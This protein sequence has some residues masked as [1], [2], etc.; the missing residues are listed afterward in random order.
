[1][2]GKTST[3]TSTV[4]IPKEVLAR[5][6][7]VNAR[8]ENT[9]S[10]PF[11]QYSTNPNA[12]V[13]PLNQQQQ[14]GI[15]NINQAATMGPQYFN[16]AAG[17][18]M[19]GAGAVNPQ[20]YSGAAVQ[21]YMNP[22]ISNVADTTAAQMK[23]LYGQQA[24]ELKGGAIR[25]G[26][27]G[28]DRAGIAQ[29]N[30]ANQQSLAFGQQMAN[31]Y[32]Q[33][34]GQAQQQFNQQQ[35][36]NLGAEQANQQRLLAA[37]QQLGGLGA[38]AQQ[39]AL[40]GAQAQLGA[41]TLGQQTEQAGL[42]ALYNQ[43]L[44]Q[45]AY[46]FQ[47]SQ[48]LANIAMGTG[49]LS[50]STQTTTQPAPFFSDER[51][52]DNIEPIGETYDGQKIVKFNYKGDKQK[53]I[54]LVAQDVE[55][56]HPEAVGLAGGLKTVDYDGATREAARMGRYM[57]GLASEGGAVIPMRAG[58]GFAIGGGV[59]EALAR[60]A[61]MYAA[62][63][64]GSV[65]TARQL[66]AGIG[67]HGRVPEA[68]LPVGRLMTPDQK[69][70]QQ[71]SGL[72]QG[73]NAYEKGAKIAEMFSKAREGLSK[74]GASAGT[75]TPSAAT[76]APSASAPTPSAA[77]K[78]DA[79]L[80][81]S[82]GE[83]T[84]YV[85]PEFEEEALGAFGYAKNGGRIRRDAGG[86]VP[87]TDE[88]T[89]S[90]KLDIPTDLPEF[91]L[92][93]HNTPSGSSGSSDLS[94]LI[95]LGKMVI[96]FLP[97]EQGGR[98]HK[99][100]GGGT[101]APAEDIP[102]SV[103]K[104][105]ISIESSGKHFDKNGQPLTSPK[106]AI[107]IAQVMPTTAP[108]AA[109]MA[110]LPFDEKRYLTDPEYN[111][112]IGKAY[113]KNQYKTFGDF[114]KAAAAYNAGPGR[115]NAAMKKAAETGADWRAFLPKETRDYIAKFASDEA[116]LPPKT[117]TPPKSEGLM[118][119][120]GMNEDTLVPLLAGV[121][122]MLS[123]RSP[124]LGSAIGEGLVGGVGAYTGL[125]GLQAEVAQR[126]AQTEE[127]YANIARSSA[128]FSPT[129]ETFFLTVGPNGYEW[130][131]EV[132]YREA[133]EKGTPPRVDPRGQNWKANN[134]PPPPFA[135]SG[136]ETGTNAPGLGGAPAPA[137]A[138]A[139]TEGLGGGEKVESVTPAPAPA[140]TEA[141][142]AGPAPAPAATETPP[143]A[144]PSIPQPTAF[145]V[146]KTIEP[147]VAN[148]VKEVFSRG[149]LFA[150]KNYSDL[151]TPQIEVGNRAEKLQ[152]GLMLFAGKMSMRPRTDELMTPGT[153][154]PILHNAFKALNNIASNFGMGEPI[155]PKDIDNQG[156]ILKKYA[157][158]RNEAT[159]AGNQR[160]VAALQKFEEQFPG[161]GSTHGESAINLANII[162]DNRREAVLKDFANSWMSTAKKYG[163]PS[164]ALTG[165]KMIEEFNKRYGDTFQRDRESFKQL[166]QTVVTE[167]GTPKGKPVMSPMGRPYTWLSYLQEQGQNL[168]PKQVEWVANTFGPN[169][170]TYFPNIRIKKGAE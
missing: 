10:Q 147:V 155:S 34:F 133:L 160:A 137:P 68:N 132:K 143:T 130:M 63:E 92:P 131:N 28:G 35:A 31:I 86:V 111:E 151:I 15:S 129:G 121:G 99:D 64:K 8:A 122:S 117:D 46:P 113:F 1:M 14:L 142:K 82:E 150:E 59:D 42:T 4:A 104:K 95:A 5:Y 60:Q 114:E 24:E 3:S 81:G 146:D 152:D 62:M 123:S 145:V 76:V 33:G 141:P 120:I 57:G 11:Q 41:G 165:A 90:K 97:F 6:N 38:T 44:Q 166:Y 162:V 107:G 153:F 71:E 32:G 100:N 156:A 43:F 16:T 91:M 49:A 74:L 96:P 72:E 116:S 157:E 89:S 161:L 134:L 138:G 61:Q 36:V 124:Y 51:T 75:K 144:E 159:N 140:T 78:T 2:G 148:T 110:G 169:I 93:K 87:Y 115:L 69:F 48:F 103:W 98:V 18:T 127:T 17:M 112:T 56:H 168:S 83:K 54:G 67:T 30:L 88:E 23:N 149:P 47:V 7:A 126:K 37:G 53:Q 22:Y 55:R 19:A 136:A 105:I 101:T 52:K 40:Q 65:P 128:V 45:Q 139:T 135:K 26:A 167:D 13:A 94:T 66:M 25:A 9:A 85:S 29:G 170:L 154:A 80:A 50:G 118:S 164:P 20:Q 70:E 77:P 119:K 108:E 21:Q 27:F 125:Q 79:G 84:S 109:R 73:L 158:L 106:G 102:D 163:A 39:S 58:Q 12:F